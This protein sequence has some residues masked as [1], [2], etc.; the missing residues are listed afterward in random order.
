MAKF[1]IIL[2]PAP[3]K[4]ALESQ[5]TLI[6]FPTPRPSQPV[7][8]RTPTNLKW[9]VLGVEGF[10]TVLLASQAWWLGLFGIVLIAITVISGRAWESEQKKVFQ[11]QD[12]DYQAQLQDWNHKKRLY[13]RSQ[14]QE[15]NIKNYQRQAV[16]NIL[17]QTQGTNTDSNAT[18][19]LLDDDLKQS[20]ESYFGDKILQGKQ[21]LKIGRWK[22]FTPDCIYYDPIHNLW[23]DIEVD[24][25]YYRDRETKEFLPQ[26]FVGDDDWR[27]ERLLEKLWIVIRFAEDQ[28]FDSIDSCC[29]VVAQAIATVTKDDSVLAKFEHIPDLDPMPQWTREEAEAMIQQKTSPR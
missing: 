17:S 26:H 6:P 15:K 8:Y 2:Y 21:A 5:A 27:D 10:L 1:P 7:R 23:I 3:I 9:I 16:L 11:R 19:G 22:P 13:E 18:D 14:L 29:K 4:A 12:R 25:P 24:N 20:L 28:V